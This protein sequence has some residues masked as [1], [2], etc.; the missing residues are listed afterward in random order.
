M[1]RMKY[2]LYVRN[3]VGLFFF[4]SV[5]KKTKGAVKVVCGYVRPGRTFIANYNEETRGTHMR[6][7]SHTILQY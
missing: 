6:V 1:G 2:C 4:L 5:G 7:C 3:K